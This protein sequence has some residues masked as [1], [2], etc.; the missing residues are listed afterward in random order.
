MQC[1]ANAMQCIACF[2]LQFAPSAPPPVPPEPDSAE[3]AEIANTG[4]MF[5]PAA[6]TFE[7]MFTGNE[8]VKATFI[9]HGGGE[10]DMDTMAPQFS[11]T[12]KD[13]EPPP[14]DT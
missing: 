14:S 6:G 11:D 1:N 8:P 2:A 5:G 12:M 13:V 4:T 10:M 9:E 7:A 3:M